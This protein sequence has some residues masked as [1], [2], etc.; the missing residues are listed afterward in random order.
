[1]DVLSVCRA[2][3]I[4]FWDIRLLLIL[5]LIVFFY[6]MGSYVLDSVWLSSMV[7][8]CVPDLSS[9]ARLTF[10][11]KGSCLFSFPFP[12]WGFLRRYSVPQ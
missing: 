5:S 1:M 4:S 3:H 6:E 9:S 10:P 2:L 8:L 7:L 11:K 12:P